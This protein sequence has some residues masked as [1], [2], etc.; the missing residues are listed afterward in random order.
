VSYP[1]KRRLDKGK[2]AT[3]KMERSEIL[4]RTKILNIP[5]IVNSMH[6]LDYLTL[7]F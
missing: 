1:S 4:Q 5:E 7:R 3:N 6:F 2:Y